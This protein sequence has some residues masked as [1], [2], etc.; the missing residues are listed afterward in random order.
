MTEFDNDM[1]FPEITWLGKLGADHMAV[2]GWTQGTMQDLRGHVCLTGALQA[3]NHGHGQPGDW[4]IAREVF[5]KRN[6]AED[7]NDEGDRVQAEVEA[8]LRNNPIYDAELQSVLGPQWREIVALTRRNSALTSTEEN[9]LNKI[10]PER[11]TREVW[12]AIGHEWQ[13]SAVSIASTMPGTM[14]MIALIVRHQIGK[15]PGWTQDEY[16]RV[17][18]PWRRIIGKVHP[19]DE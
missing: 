6:R 17:T 12:E 9:R 11:V 15:I 1:T 8:E 14:T 3:A 19:D 4:K 18:A 10:T 2:H 13:M 7:W 16:N 5:R